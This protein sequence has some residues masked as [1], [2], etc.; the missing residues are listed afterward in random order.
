MVFARASRSRYALF[1]LRQW[2]RNACV[3]FT[4]KLYVHFRAWVIIVIY[5]HTRRHSTNP[6]MAQHTSYHK[7]EDRMP[8]R[9]AFGTAT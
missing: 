2:F 3:N 1:A 7:S 9:Y 4:E 5:C 6:V 8:L